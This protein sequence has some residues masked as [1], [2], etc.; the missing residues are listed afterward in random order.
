MRPIDSD[1]L[2][3][4]LEKRIR[5][6]RS[7][8]E[9]VRDIIPMVERQPTIGGDMRKNADMADKNAIDGLKNLRLFMEFKDKVKDNKF[10]QF[11]YDCVDMA[12]ESLKKQMPHKIFKHG[13]DYI[14]PVC[15]YTINCCANIIYHANYC[16]ECGT[17][18]DWSDEE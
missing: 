17:K 1:L 11:T 13:H 5:T 4:D 7:T 6:Q 2:I 18:I 12:I 8:M 10:N 14:C 3:D 9:I 15:G 16:E